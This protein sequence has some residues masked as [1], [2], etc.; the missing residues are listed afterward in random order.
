MRYNGTSK[1][2]DYIYIDKED[3]NLKGLVY[4][5][6]F[7]DDSAYIGI[8]TQKLY[9]RMLK[10]FDDALRSVTKNKQSKIHKKLL[11]VMENGEKVYIKIMDEALADGSNI[12]I[13]SWILQDFEKMYVEYYKEEQYLHNTM[14]I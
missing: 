10:H 8:T 7:D 1:Y 9:T 11:S 12:N 14:L 5:M 13:E 4:K 3:M 6:E 2:N